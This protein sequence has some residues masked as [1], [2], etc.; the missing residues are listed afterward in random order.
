MLGIFKKPRKQSLY[1]CIQESKALVRKHR[2][3]V[4]YRHVP[5]RLNGIPDAMCR[6][7][8]QSQSDHD[9]RDGKLGEGMP[10]LDVD[11]LYKEVDAA[12]TL[13]TLK[14]ADAIDCTF[15]AWDETLRGKACK[16]CSLL[17][18]E[19]NMVVWERCNEVFHPHCANS[20]GLT[21]IHDGPWY[22]FRCVGELYLNGSPDPIQD[23]PLIY[24]LFRG[25]EPEDPEVSSRIHRMA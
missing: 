21:P 24:Y 1:H 7:A 25:I 16:G 6:L 2:L 18:D 19:A 10:T 9:Y 12:S 5:R 11:A 17:N 23:I 15:A 3:I 4:A 8:F 20:R 22:C 14:E 13:P